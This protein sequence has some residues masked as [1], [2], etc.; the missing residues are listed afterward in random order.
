[1]FILA[2]S[3]WK[4]NCSDPECGPICDGA[5]CMN[6]QLIK[7]YFMEFECYDAYGSSDTKNLTLL[8]AENEAP[9]LFNLPGKTY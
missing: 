3:V 2:Y 4:K 6:F 5:G 7:E 9:V 1:M 8:V